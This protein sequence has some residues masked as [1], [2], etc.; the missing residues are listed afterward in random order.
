MKQQPGQDILVAGSGAL[1][2]ML[3]QHNLVD[4]YQ[5]MV[6]PVILGSGM[7][8]FEDGVHKQSLKLIEARPFSTG[9][10]VLTYQAV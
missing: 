10:V 4:E 3:A 1:V 7:R 5:L 2:S 8:L 9:V 6:H